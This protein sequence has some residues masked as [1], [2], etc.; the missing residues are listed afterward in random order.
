MIFPEYIKAGD[1]IGV[2]APSAGVSKEADIVRFKSAKKRLEDFGYKVIFTDDVF[3]DDGNGRSTDA[4]TRAREFMELIENP[5]VKYICSAKGGDFLMEILPYLDFNKIK[6]NPKWIQGF[7]DNTSLTFNIC[8][9]CDIATVYCN[10]FGDFGMENWHSSVEENLKILEGEI[11]SQK[12]YD[13]YEDDYYDRVTGLESYN[14]TKPVSMKLYNGNKGEGKAD[15]SGRMIG[16]CLDVVMDTLGTKYENVKGFVE[17]Y[18]DEGIVWYLESF[19][20]NSE[21]VMRNMWKMKELGWF[22]NTKGILF[23]REL[24]YEKFSETE[25][26]EACMTMLEELKIPVIFGVDI[27]HKAPQL[28]IINGAY[29]TINYDNGLKLTYR[30]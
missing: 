19:L 3:K 23:G 25:F 26:D 30:K 13:M 12:N 16:G 7:S 9:S 28:C 24:M 8:T 29:Y 22:E 6:A 20:N 5:E 17:K 10:N 11:N 4:I 2:T 27:G 1:T 18:K 21:G 14:L 15:F